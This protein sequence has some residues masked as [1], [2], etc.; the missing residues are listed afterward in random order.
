MRMHKLGAGVACCIALA[1]ASLA[2]S[3]K[4]PQS[5]SGVDLNAIDKS[6]DPCKDFYQYACGNWIKNNPIPADESR[7]GRFDELFERNQAILWVIL[8]DSEQHQSRSSIDQKIGGF[9]QSCMAEDVIQQR[10][11]AALD[12]GLTQISRIS[13]DRELMDE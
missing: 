2:Q 11:T 12:A 9:Y 8:E 5:Q 4:R 7:W 13:N 1:G 10:G 3:D 6:A